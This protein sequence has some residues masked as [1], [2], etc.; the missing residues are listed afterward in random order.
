MPTP[1]DDPRPHRR[2]GWLPT[3][4]QAAAAVLA[5]A[6]LLYVT[7]RFVIESIVVPSSSMRPTI[8]PNERVLVQ[9]LGRPPT[10]RFDVVVVDQPAY[11]RR[12]VKRVVG[13]PGERVRVEDGWRVVIDGR[14]LDYA[15]P[16][17]G[18]VS[19]AGDHLLDLSPS[20]DK[21]APGA[22]AAT[23]DVVLGP[24]EFYVLGDNRLGSED[25]RTF[26]P[27]RRGQIEGTA[28]LVWYSFDVPAGRLRADRLFARV[29]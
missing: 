6:A 18:R 25:S 14:S 19:E 4:R 29:R 2:R 22:R 5:A 1:A 24:D 26:G 7:D 16:A 15:V 27:V 21:S 12:V 9:K 23:A 3:R 20:D 17:G 11:G 13:L 28:R 10:R 8:L